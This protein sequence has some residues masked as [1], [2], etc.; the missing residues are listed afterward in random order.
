MLTIIVWWLGVFSLWGFF[1]VALTHLFVGLLYYN[2]LKA[3]VTDPGVIP[4]SWQ[5][6]ARVEI[7][8]E[9]VKEADPDK[10]AEELDSRFC[11]KCRVHKAPRAH[12]CSECDRCVLKMDH[13]CPW[14]NNC[15][16]HYNH[17]YFLLFLW[18]LLVEST[19]MV[20]V[21]IFRIAF[22]VKEVEEQ[23]NVGPIEVMIIGVMLM[24]IIPTA[25]GVGCLLGYQMSLVIENT[26]SIE[27]LEKE[28]EQRKAKRKGK[29]YRFQ[30]DRGTCENLRDVFGSQFLYWVLPTQPESDG[31]S[32]TTN[33]SVDV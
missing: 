21:Y 6:K 17:K 7:D 22:M 15:V 20:V 26:T 28:R 25:L 18:Y 16:G 14:I 4:K 31:L 13:H 12:H 27:A 23:G 11:K 5:P 3:V 24:I 33:K 30:Y 10:P 32:Y 1:N 8:L 2:Y 19:H 29:M 9:S